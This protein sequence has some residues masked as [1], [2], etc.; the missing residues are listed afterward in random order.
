MDHLLSKEF[1]KAGIHFSKLYHFL[2]GG[3]TYTFECKALLKNDV[4]NVY[5]LVAIKL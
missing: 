5:T 3:R 4:Q 2:S 1:T